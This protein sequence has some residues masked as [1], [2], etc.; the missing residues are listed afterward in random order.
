MQCDTVHHQLS[1]SFNMLCSINNKVLQVVPV[2]MAQ[3]KLQALQL[4]TQPCCCSWCPIRP[5]LLLPLLLLQ[6]QL[7]LLQLLLLLL[8]LLK[9]L[10]LLLHLL[11]QLHLMLQA[12]P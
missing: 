1:L 5:Q 2:W 3:S 10:Q 8:Q 12:Q 6:L 7:Q 11:L 9:L 4:L